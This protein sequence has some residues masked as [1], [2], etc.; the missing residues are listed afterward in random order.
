MN[1]IS[2]DDAIKELNNMA[3]ILLVQDHISFK[4]TK[5]A[6]EVLYMAINSLEN[7]TNAVREGEK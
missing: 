4:D 3:L 5:K 6:R 7:E 2:K 1:D